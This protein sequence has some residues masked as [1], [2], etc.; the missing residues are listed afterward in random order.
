MASK[1]GLNRKKTLM[2]EPRELAA[3]NAL[4]RV[5]GVRSRNPSGC[6][7][8]AEPSP[9]RAFQ[10]GRDASIRWLPPLGKIGAETT[11]VG[12]GY[13]M[14]L[15]PLAACSSRVGR[16]KIINIRGHRTIHVAI[17]HKRCWRWFARP[18]SRPQWGKGRLD[19]EASG[20]P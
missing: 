14:G 11:S 16:R 15:Y 1:E 13:A 5:S 20:L 10:T 19:Y 8:P 9:R 17:P 12:M 2:E 3:Q 7:P 18:A 4:P 6:S